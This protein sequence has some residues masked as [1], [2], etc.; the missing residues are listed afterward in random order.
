RVKN[1][2]DKKKSWEEI[3]KHEPLLERDDYLLFKEDLHT[4]NTK[5]WVA[6][7]KRLR[8]QNIGN[9]RLGSGGYIGIKPIWE[10]EDTEIRRLG[11]PNMFD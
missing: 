10:K 2:I 11:K 9:H 4:D 8:D 7:G 3:K 1:R 5:E 6:W